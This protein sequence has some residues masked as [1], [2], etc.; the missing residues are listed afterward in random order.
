MD[1]RVAEG[2]H[3]EHRRPGRDLTGEQGER[4][5]PWRA[6]A[7][8]G[9]RRHGRSVDQEERPETTDADAGVSENLA[10][11]VRAPADH[12]RVADV[13]DAVGVVQTGGEKHRP[14]RE[15]GGYAGRHDV[16]RQ[17]Q[18]RRQATR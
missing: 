7:Q 14:E 1:L 5:A 10:A 4:R 3:E 17:K 18:E 11:P 6:G 9:E 8:R 16:G 12:N 15:R 2:Q 13:E